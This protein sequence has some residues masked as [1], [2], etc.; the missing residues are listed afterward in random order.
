VGEDSGEEKKNSGK[1][2]LSK[3]RREGRKLGQQKFVPAGLRRSLFCM[4]REKCEERLDIAGGGKIIGG[5]GL[6]F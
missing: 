1:A 3:G 6:P 2:R 4:E 5:R